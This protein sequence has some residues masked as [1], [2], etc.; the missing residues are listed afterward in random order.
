MADVRLPANVISQMMLFV[1]F[2]CTSTL[3]LN[4]L[5]TL[6]LTPP[7]RADMHILVDVIQAT[8]TTAFPPLDYVVGA[9]HLPCIWLVG[10]DIL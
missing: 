1:A 5:L 8:A 2:Q 6:A 4:L 7:R 10:G 3:T 9:G